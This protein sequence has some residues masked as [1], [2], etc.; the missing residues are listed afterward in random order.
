MD[1]GVCVYNTHKVGVRGHAPLE[2]Y[3]RLLLRPFLDHK[4]Y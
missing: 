3:F 1:K 4:P 2:K